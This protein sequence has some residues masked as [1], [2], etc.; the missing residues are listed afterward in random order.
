MRIGVHF[1]A[2]LFP[3]WGILVPTLTV[4]FIVLLL[5]LPA[6]VPLTYSLAF[7]GILIGIST[8]CA[9]TALICDD[10]T[11]RVSKDGLSF[12]LRFWPALNYQHQ[13]PW[14]ELGAI[15]VDWK[16]N[17]SFAAEDKIHLVF[18]GGARVS[19]KLKHVQLEELE[20]FFVALECCA[21][22]CERDAELPDLETSIQAKQAGSSLTF[23]E[24]WDNSLANRFSG[25]KYNPL[26]PGIRLL[27]GHFK[28]LK[29]LTFGGSSATYLAHST[30]G[31]FVV[32]KEFSFTHFE[33]ATQASG[34][35]NYA[36]VFNDRAVI[37]SSLNHPQV[38]KLLDQ[39]IENGRHYLVFVHVD[40]TSL[41]QLVMQRKTLPLATVADITQQ[42]VTAL[43]YI[44][45]LSPPVVHGNIT[46]DNLLITSEGK[47][48]IS[49]FAIA[50]SVSA[51][52]AG[53][54]HLRL[55]Y[56]APEQ[57]RCSASSQSDIYGLG[58]TLFF[59]LT[60]RQP[61]ALT[62]ATLDTE[63]GG[64][65]ELSEIV[66]SCTAQEE[67]NR[68]DCAQVVELLNK[69]KHRLTTLEGAPVQANG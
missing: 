21:P 31:D 68:P 51:A 25:L 58:A 41:S 22:S 7:I 43:T 54:Q 46:P 10:N 64:E 48:L 33:N 62:Q 29:Q 15:K 52:V 11:I 26:E 39:F 8:V 67:Q 44:Q 66:A 20:R 37:L 47:I 38:E 50:D 35:D 65:V 55:P 61:E 2:V 59:L 45:S 13:R 28:I 53:S 30:T 60:G 32:L 49:N 27:D 57:F 36:S 5:R 1:L 19:L 23:S 4:L 12:P 40:G 6:N 17:S 34:T 42:L 9:L 18:R 69:R 3:I 56:T 63:D 24:I 14:T 16:R